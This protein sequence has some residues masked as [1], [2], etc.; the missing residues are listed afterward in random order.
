MVPIPFSYI[1]GSIIVHAVATTAVSF[2]FPEELTELKIEIENQIDHS[3]V[4]VCYYSSCW[5]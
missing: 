3:E 5:L 4:P 1:L 2:R